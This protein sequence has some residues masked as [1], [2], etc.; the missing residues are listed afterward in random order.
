MTVSQPQADKKYFTAEE[1][2]RMLPLVRAIVQDIV[3]LYESLRERHGQLQELNEETVPLA[4][5][6]ELEGLRDQFDEDEER[7]R[8]YVEELR[9]LGV[10]FKGF[11]LGLVDFPCWRDG[12]EVYLCWK[13]GEAAVEHWHEVADGFTGRQK[14]KW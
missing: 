5:R 9:R 11:D 10:E 2:N 6:E 8:D 3:V 1:A 14:V 4:R 7:L 12:R 13:L